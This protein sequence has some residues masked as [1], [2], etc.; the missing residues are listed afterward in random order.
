MLTAGLDR[1]RMYAFDIACNDDSSFVENTNTRRVGI[2]SS[3]PEAK[4]N[5][6]LPDTNTHWVLQSQALVYEDVQ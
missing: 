2:S 6:R 3:S 5:L 1:C 4:K